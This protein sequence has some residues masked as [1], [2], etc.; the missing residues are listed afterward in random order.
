MRSLTY[1]LVRF[2]GELSFDRLPDD[3]AHE[4]KRMLLDSI[5]CAL[6]GLLV[7]KGKISI[8]LLKP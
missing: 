4:V 2:A 8:T 1:D 6:G 5:A 7:D 3:V